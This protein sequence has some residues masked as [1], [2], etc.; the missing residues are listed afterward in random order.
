MAHKL[1]VSGSTIYSNPKLF[2][3]L[4]WQGI[5]HIEIGEF[6][7]ENSVKDFLKL[8]KE[9]QISFGIHSPLLRGGSKYDLIEKVQYDVNYA[10]EQLESEAKRL[11]AL[12]ADY[13]LVHFP[14]FKGEIIGDT[15][16]LIE[17]GLSKLSH[18]QSQY[19]IDLICEPKVGLNRSSAGINYLNKFPIE[20][21]E[22]YNVKLCIDI[23]DYLI[24][25]GDEI[26]NY[27]SKWK[28]S[29][30]VVH[31]HN[32]HYEEDDY[33]WIPIHPSQELTSKHKTKNII[34]LLSQSKDVFF[35]FE[36]T[37]ETNPSK[38]FVMEGYKWVSWL[39]GG[40]RE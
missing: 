22:K 17:E 35:V 31:L 1:G 6:P 11:S 39:I 36:H 26:L 25:V 15:N 37:P 8:C 34:E 10:W 20:T 32:V 33:F 7:D 29:I 38:E 9:K 13:L 16:R 19:S 23:G 28:E 12:G 30:K 24:A 27:L 2:S 40:G 5:D 14:Y 18:I 21:W 4:F 3:E